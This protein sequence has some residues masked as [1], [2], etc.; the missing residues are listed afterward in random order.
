MRYQKAN[1][2]GNFLLFKDS[3]NNYLKSNF[4]NVLLFKYKDMDQFIMEEMY[5]L[6]YFRLF[7]KNYYQY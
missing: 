6:N 5:L 7:Q 2:D 3:N 4:L 1:V